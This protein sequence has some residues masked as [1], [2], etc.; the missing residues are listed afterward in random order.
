MRLVWSTQ[1]HHVRI[2]GC[3]IIAIRQTEPARYARFLFIPRV[4]SPQRI[5]EAK[6][7]LLRDSAA[8]P[9]PIEKAW[10]WSAL[11]SLNAF[12]L[13]YGGASSAAQYTASVFS[14]ASLAGI[15][16]GGSVIGGSVIVV[17]MAE[18]RASRGKMTRCACSGMMTYAQR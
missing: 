15:T 8:N 14:D 6:A 18:I 3:V 5:A 9:N 4:G 17:R 13:D 7:I 2:I 11:A 12:L 16:V 1:T 10:S